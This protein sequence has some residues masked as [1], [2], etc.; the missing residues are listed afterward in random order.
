MITEQLEET[1]SL[2]VLDGLEPDERAAF[3]KQLA[4]SEE[5]Q[6]LVDELT[7]TAASLAL[8]APL[9]MPPPHLEAA[10][11]REIRESKIARPNFS[12]ARWI[13]WAVAACLALSTGLLYVARNKLERRVAE[14]QSGQ[15]QARLDLARV[16]S[17]R[18]RAS[19]KVAD[20][21]KRD[22][23][24]NAK[25]AG[26]S[27]ERE[28]M[29]SEIARLLERDNLAQMQI[30][31]LTSKLADAPK[32][33]AFVI[34]DAEKQRGVLTTVDVPPNAAD[35]D[36]QLWVVDPKYQVPVDAGVFSVK[37]GEATKILFKP[38]SPVSSADAFAISLERKGGVPKA[39]GP[40]VLVGK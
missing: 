8:A 37:S 40:I 11:M 30:A 9:R 12:A 20:L 27:R 34:W 1:A 35:R 15:E 23:D 21:E 22:T 33:T 4:G 31:T 39:E 29:A 16:S 26:L 17:E 36:Y 19:N 5:L 3:E 6:R 7:A 38:K 14:L 24:A 13:P 18:D 25:I 2:Y 28:R 10:I 32:A